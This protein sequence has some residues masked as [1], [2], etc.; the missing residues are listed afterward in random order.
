MAKLKAEKAEGVA[1]TRFLLTLNSIGQITIPVVI[2]KMLNLT[3]KSTVVANVDNGI[4]KITPVEMIPKART[5]EGRVALQKELAKSYH[6]GPAGKE[7]NV[8]QLMK[9]IEE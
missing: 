2:R 7:V 4:I 5:L 8:S 9:E 3:A 6:K 1:K